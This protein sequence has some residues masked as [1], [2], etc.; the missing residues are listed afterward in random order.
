MK[1]CKFCGSENLSKKNQ[2]FSNGTQHISVKC[3]NCGSHLGFEK[4]N[5][6]FDILIAKDAS[7][8]SSD[9]IKNLSMSFFNKLNESLGDLKK[10]RVTIVIKAR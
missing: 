4:Q 2:V 7:I 6:G 9:D 5:N 10:R 8:S 3:M 1:F